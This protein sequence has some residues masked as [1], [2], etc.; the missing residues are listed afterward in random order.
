[1]PSLPSPRFGLN[2]MVA[3]RL[4]LLELFRL[5]RALGITAV[6]I[7]N[8]LPGRPIADG[9]PPHLVR[10]AARDAGV[11]VLSINALQRFDEWTKRREAEAAALARY[12]SGAGARALVLV[13]TNDGSGA[14]K[15]GHDELCRSLAMLRPILDDFGVLGLVE[16]LGF[17]TSSLRS[18][19]QAVEAIDAV[20]GRDSFRL[21]H[22][23]FHHALTGE[24]E[25]Y[26][27]LTGLV[28]ISGVPD[29]GPSLGDLTDAHRGLVDPDDRL[30]NLEQ[31]ESLLA[32]G[33]PGP[34]SFEPFAA[35]VHGLADPR[36]ALADSMEFIRMG[37]A[38]R[39]SLT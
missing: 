24:P 13:P 1:M 15:A 10:D 22:D 34:L 25:L 23:T 2:H 4:D 6:E 31:I 12:A 20:H 39:G 16:P 18:K 19:R 27:G 7:R 14:G 33:Y 28:H 8:D 26:P 35:Q 11:S 17:R 38:A 29:R 37:L 3:P 36:A 9:T 5:A 30:G 21:V 32:A